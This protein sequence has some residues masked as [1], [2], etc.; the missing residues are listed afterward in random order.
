M[1]T[2]APSYFCCIQLQKG[3]LEMGYSAL[4]VGQKTWMELLPTIHMQG[5][6]KQRCSV[7]TLVLDCFF[8][9]QRSHG[10]P[11]FSMCSLSLS[12]ACCAYAINR[13]TVVSGGSALKYS[14]H[15][16]YSW[17]GVSSSCTYPTILTWL[18]TITVLIIAGLKL[19]C[20]VFRV[21]SFKPYS[22]GRK[23]ALL[24]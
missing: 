24:P 8:N 14:I 23:S 2:L 19:S 15:L 16:I 22:Y 4:Q 10:S 21:F 12:I 17:E 7:V 11:T 5:K 13:L 9:F 18:L 6:H 20:R 1:H 3:W